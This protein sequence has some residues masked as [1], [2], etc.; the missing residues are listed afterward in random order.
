ML[1][2]RSI[3]APASGRE[4]QRS[5]SL[6]A[7]GTGGVMSGENR[8]SARKASIGSTRVARFDGS[9]LAPSA[10]RISS[11]AT[12]TNVEGSRGATPY[13]SPAASC[14]A[15]RAPTQRAAEH[16][17][18]TAVVSLPY[19]VAEHYDSRRAGL[20]VRG[21]EPTTEHG[22]HG[23]A[24]DSIERPRLLVQGVLQQL[25]AGVQPTM[26]T[27]VLIAPLKSALGN[28]EALD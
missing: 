7:S 25:A 14:V 15:A 13:S 10:K 18:R 5:N 8:Q 1:H 24:L 6:G 2:L 9:Q 19:V 3:A 12:P 21:R 23:K 17:G 26:A 16:V 4:P 22:H 11:P 28:P 27:M 20:G